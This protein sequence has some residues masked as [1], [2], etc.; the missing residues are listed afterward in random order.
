MQSLNRRMVIGVGWMVLL[1]WCL[2]GIGVVSTIILARLLTPSDFGIVAMAMS[3]IAAFDLMTE[4]SF[5]LALIQNQ[6]AG[7]DHYDTAWTFNL[8]FVLSAAI[9][10][11]LVSAQAGRFFDEPRLPIVLVVLAL[12]FAITGFE[13]IAVVNFRKELNFDK[14]FKLQML[15]KI[16]GFV[17]VVPLAFILRSYWAL[18]AGMLAGNIVR[19]ILSYWYLPYRPKVCFAEA[20]QLFGFSIW[21]FV[22]KILIFLRLRA[23]DFILAKMSGAEVLGVYKIGNEISQLS[24]SEIATPVNRAVFP[25]YAKMTDDLDVLR[26][27]YFDVVTAVAILALPAGIGLAITADLIVPLFLGDQW[28]KAIPVIQVLAIAGALRAIS[29][30]SGSVFLALGKPKFVT[31]LAS[32]NIAIL[33][34]VAVMLVRQEGAVGLAW[35]TLAGFCVTLPV[36]CFLTLRLL[37]A[38]WAT[39][40][41]CLWRPVISTA[42]MWFVVDRIVQMSAQQDKGPVDLAIDVLVAVSAGAIVYAV[43]LLLSWQLSGRPEGVEYTAL[44]KIYDQIRKWHARIK[45]S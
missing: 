11:L 16:A 17:V 7:K 9:F 32:L 35:A 27:G 6:S 37:D 28:I 33:L 3:V 15:Q 31:V 40:F 23:G 1:R 36:T 14:E 18:V 10:I 25:A 8:L 12:G 34:P 4:F 21:I 26:K 30:N 5:D 39:L 29:L 42:A 20:R 44:R 43:V 38:K 2:R 41:G 13:N 45:T 19:V 24:G 22:N